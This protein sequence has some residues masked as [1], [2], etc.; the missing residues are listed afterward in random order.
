MNGVGENNNEG[1]FVNFPTETT[2]NVP[3]LNQKRIVTPE[4]VQ[5][6]FPIGG[7]NDM[8]T[9]GIFHLGFEE[10]PQL[11]GNLQ[12]TSYETIFRMWG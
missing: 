7:R 4:K 9:P 2:I 8:V 3:A 1:N 12:K 6:G 5:N 10:S 11:D